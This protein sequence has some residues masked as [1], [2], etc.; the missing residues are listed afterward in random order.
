MLSAR[1]SAVCKEC[2]SRH[3]RMH[4]VLYTGL[5]L[6][7][8]CSARPNGQQQ[9]TSQSHSLVDILLLDCFVA[10]KN[11]SSPFASLFWWLRI[12]PGSVTPLLLHH[13]APCCNS[14]HQL[15]IASILGN[16]GPRTAA[17]R[18]TV[19]ADQ[20]NLDKQGI[21][22]IF[23]R[24]IK[25]LSQIKKRKPLTPHHPSIRS[26]STRKMFP[27]SVP[28]PPVQRQLSAGSSNHHSPGLSSCS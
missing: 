9:S 25:A 10:S 20:D 11:E 12:R 3:T 7:A 22:W 15:P 6:T 13:A 17:G 18:T 23:W 27:R 19:F 8:T 28:N 5:G 21:V 1:C 14:V 4:Q 2:C 26:R 16:S 24:N